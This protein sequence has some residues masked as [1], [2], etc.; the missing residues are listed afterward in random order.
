MLIKEGIIRLC[1]LIKL[2]YSIKGQYFINLPYLEKLW[3]VGLPIAVMK[4]HEQAAL[5]GKG[6]F[7]L[8]FH[9]VVHH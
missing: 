6:L 8:H 5:G 9:T 1:F 2:G 3:I 7:D 4:H